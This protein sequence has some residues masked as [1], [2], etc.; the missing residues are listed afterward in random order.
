MSCTSMSHRW[1][2]TSQQPHTPDLVSSPFD[3]SS[4]I[5]LLFT[6]NAKMF[7]LPWVRSRSF[8]DSEKYSERTS[9]GVGFFSLV[10][11]VWTC[12]RWWQRRVDGKVKSLHCLALLFKERLFVRRNWHTL[13]TWNGQFKTS[14]HARSS[15]W[16]KWME[17]DSGR[18]GS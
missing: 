8:N 15:H 6:D 14:T 11:K 5:Y 17:A 4:E 10:L 9:S 18:G 12:T 7:T 1:L 3:A 16:G 13:G 2:R